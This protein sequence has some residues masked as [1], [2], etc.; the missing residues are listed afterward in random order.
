MFAML[1]GN[2]PYT[3]EH[4]N[5]IDLYHK[6]MQRKIAPFPKHVS[7][8]KTVIILIKFHRIGALTYSILP[9]ESISENGN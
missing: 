3:M 7:P 6:M 1:T 9:I 8:G 5:I 2:L 4:F